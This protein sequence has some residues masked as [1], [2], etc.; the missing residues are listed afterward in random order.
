MK[1]PIEAS[2]TL[3]ILTAKIKPVQLIEISN[4]VIDNMI[5]FFNE[6]KIKIN[7][8]NIVKKNTNP[9]KPTLP[10]KPT[11]TNYPSYN[12]SSIR[13]CSAT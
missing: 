8:L 10:T 5:I 1:Y 13:C 7:S 9:T 12:D 4:E 3:L 11:F 2:W 6:K